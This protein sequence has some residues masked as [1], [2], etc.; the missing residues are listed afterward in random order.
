MKRKVVKKQNAGIKILDDRLI[1]QHNKWEVDVRKDVERIKLQSAIEV[2]GV[3]LMR[4]MKKYAWWIN[5][6]KGA[7]RE[8]KMHLKY[9]CKNE[10]EKKKKKQ[11]KT[12]QNVA[13]KVE[14]DNNEYLIL[15][16][17]NV[18]SFCKWMKR[19]EEGASRRMNG[20]KIDIIIRVESEVKTCQKDCL[21]FCMIKI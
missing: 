16:Q 6:M 3:M 4:N 7:V 12:L 11:K 1:S 14:K 8:K 10:V 2:C 20:I 13:K 15:K 21:K 18:I 5:E 9:S 17:R 19:A